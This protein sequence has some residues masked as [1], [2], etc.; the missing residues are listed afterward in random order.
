MLSGE[1]DQRFDASKELWSKYIMA[2]TESVLPG[3]DFFHRKAF[4]ECRQSS[5]YDL[6]WF[7]KKYKDKLVKEL[8][9]LK[10][11]KP[12]IEGDP[13]DFLIK[14]KNG[15]IPPSEFQRV[16]P[17]MAIH[18]A[19]A[20]QEK[21]EAERKKQHEAKLLAA[22]NEKEVLAGM[23]GMQVDDEAEVGKGLEKN[24]AAH[25]TAD[26]DEMELNEILESVPDGIDLTRVPWHADWMQALLNIDR[27]IGL[28]V[29]YRPESD[30][31]GW[32]GAEEACELLFTKEDTLAEHLTKRLTLS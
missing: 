15:D 7:S 21:A 20:Q 23:Q 11:G 32:I 12:P 17:A 14:C 4:I 26:G 5:E 25:Q 1:Y 9:G 8:M 27:S 28:V 30:R 29:G 24:Q 19:Y 22:K 3:N 10:L 13:L 31:K 16:G 2:W 18:F 6:Q